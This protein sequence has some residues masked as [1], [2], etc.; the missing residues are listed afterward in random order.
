MSNHDRKPDWMIEYPF[1]SEDVAAILRRAS[2]IRNVA[3]V[4]SVEATTLDV[5]VDTPTIERLSIPLHEL[6]VQTRVSP[7][8]LEDS[9]FDT[10]AWL[11]ERIVDH[12]ARFEN[13]AFLTGDGINKPRGFLTYAT[14]P[15]ASWRWGD[16]GYVPTG[17]AAGLPSADP[18]GPIIDLIGALGVRYRQNATFLMNSATADVIRKIQDADGRLLW[19][20]AHLLGY[21]VVI[22]EEMSDVAANETPI[23]FGD[24]RAAYTIA[25]R[26]DLRILRDPFSAM[27]DVLFYASK[28]VGGDVTDFAAVKMLKVEASDDP[29]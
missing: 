26:P 10:S 17:S 29:T 15:N 28:L 4:V 18:A 9:A 24:F 16:I 1:V 8:L 22:A 19:S 12:F 13:A 25:E 6:S 5:L 27:P 20:E 11:R 23:A 2:P 7:R 3:N 14:V 21:P